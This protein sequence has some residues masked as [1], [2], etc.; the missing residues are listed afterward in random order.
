M[1]TLTIAPKERILIIDGL[2]GFAPLGILIAHI[3]YWF[4]AG[5]SP[6]GIFQSIAATSVFV[7]LRL[8]GFYFGKI[9][10]FFSFLFG[11]SFALQMESREFTVGRFC[12][13][14]SV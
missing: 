2:R 6:D 1:K 4:N 7:L 13:D 10:T 9:L 5:P 12:G 11:L 3:P 8:K 14:C